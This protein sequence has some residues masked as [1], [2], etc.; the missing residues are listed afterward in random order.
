MDCSSP[1]TP[2]TGAQGVAAIGK[3]RATQTA[4][5]VRIWAQYVTREK[6]IKGFEP[7]SARLP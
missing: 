7:K 1:R 2:R 6:P 5:R 4:Q 3:N